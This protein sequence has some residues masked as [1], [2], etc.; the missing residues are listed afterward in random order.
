MKRLLPLLVIVIFSSAAHASS[1]LDWLQQACTIAKARWVCDTADSALLIK[2]LVDGGWDRVQSTSLSFAAG[3]LQDA[4]MTAGQVVCVGS[5]VSRRCLDDMTRDA[6][7]WLSTQPDKFFENL[8]REGQSL[9][10][11]NLVQK[12]SGVSSAQPNSPTALA[13]GAIAGQPNVKAK[14][15]IAYAE[16]VRNL[17]KETEMGQLVSNSEQIIRPADPGTEDP[18]LRGVA[19]L[20]RPACDPGNPLTCLDPSSPGGGWIAQQKSRAA[21]AVSTREQLQGLVELQ[22]DAQGFG[23]QNTLELSKR[24]QQLAQLQVYTNKQLQMIYDG[25]TREQKE[26]Q[27]QYQASLEREYGQA[28]AAG[29]QAAANFSSASQMMLNNANPTSVLS[30][31]LRY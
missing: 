26:R 8:F 14:Y 30:A 9:Y 28:L 12:M 18:Y 17:K 23:A 15:Y 10:L 27:A 2:S 4:A 21:T 16:D 11:S 31:V 13:D 5:G 22:A 20:A 6:K 29:Q 3:W 7:G 25:I 24:L 1:P 19:E